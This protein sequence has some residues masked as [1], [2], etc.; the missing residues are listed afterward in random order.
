[1][2]QFETALAQAQKKQI[3]GLLLSGLLLVLV[4]TAVAGIVI[5]LGGTRIL[6]LPED[7]KE[8]AQIELANGYGIAVNHVVYSISS[9]IRASIS[10]PGFAS[11]DRPIEPHEK[12]TNIQVTLKELP[13]KLDLTTTPPND[14]TKWTID[15]VLVGI[16]EALSHQLSSGDHTLKIDSPYFSVATEPLATKRGETIERVIQLISIEGQIDVIAKPMEA[17]I[18]INGLEV[19]AADFPITRNG[20]AYDVSITHPG[21]HETIEKI[22]LTNSASTVARNYKLRKLT[23]TLS[24]QSKPKGGELLLNG[25]R[26]ASG[27]AQAVPA[28]TMH[29][30]SFFKAGYAPKK[31][32]VTLEPGEEKVVK[33]SLQQEI[34]KVELRAKPEADI[35]IHDKK[36]ATSP[37]TIELQALPTEIEFRKPGYT[38]VKRKVTP[39]SKRII[40]LTT[41]LQTELESRLT[42]SPPQYKNAVGITMKRFAPDDYVMGAPRSERGQR[43]NEFQK[44]IN[45]TRRFYSSLHEV[46]NSQFRRYRASQQGLGSHPIVGVSWLHAIGFC[47]WLSK[48]EKRTPFYIIEDNRF[49]GVNE[50][51]DGYRL[52]TEAE[53]E[54]LARKSGRESQTTFPWGDESTVP[55]KA[56]NIADESANGITRFYVPNYTDGFTRLAPIGSFAAEPSGLYDLTGN[57]REWVHDVYSVQP[58]KPGVVFTDPL[59]PRVGSGNVV[60]GSSWRSGTR[61]TLRSAYRNGEINAADD[62]GFRIGRYM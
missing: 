21:Y 4:V 44:S 36:V 42:S 18:K 10:A 38:T 35:Y 27:S 59:G 51:A 32:Q 45:L 20:G 52:L 11:L 8:R 5:S 1:M 58:P 48:L 2:S 31:I 47:N 54:W 37:T 39:T 19:A 12:G 40:V 22:E 34:G 30:V 33:L 13:A 23:A 7:A 6:V 28:L 15:D 49:K 53:W 14:R 9:N 57:A 41:R 26:I 17:L 60:R 46:S 50:Q 29:T 62:I 16:G 61:T 3:R 43:A 56:G 24:V 25:R 55:P